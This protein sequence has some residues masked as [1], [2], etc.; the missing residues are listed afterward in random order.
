[1]LQRF[2]KIYKEKSGESVHPYQKP[3]PDYIFIFCKFLVLLVMCFVAKA[4]KERADK[5]AADKA[6]ADGMEIFL[7]CCCKIYAC[8]SKPN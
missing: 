6:A 8:R 1:M 4:A 3:I 5:L 7:S 2:S